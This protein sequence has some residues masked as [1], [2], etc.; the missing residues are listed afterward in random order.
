[1]HDRNIG[2]YIEVDMGKCGQLPEGR[3]SVHH[4]PILGIGT[5]PI[6]PLPWCLSARRIRTFLVKMGSRPRSRPWS[7]SQSRSRSEAMLELPGDSTLGVFERVTVSMMNCWWAY[8]A[9][10]SGI[11]TWVRQWQESRSLG[12]I[13]DRGS[14]VPGQSTMCS[15]EETT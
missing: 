5:G 14:P 13:P 11:R 2:G 3:C 12:A 6:S 4:K 1:M 15:I 7:R 8:L 10:C 9:R